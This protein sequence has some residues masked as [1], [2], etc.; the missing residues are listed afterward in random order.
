[1]I[2]CPMI[3]ISPLKLEFP[4][5]LSVPV[6]TSTPEPLLLPKLKSPFTK[7]I[8]GLAS[9]P[10]PVGGKLHGVP[11]PQVRDWAAPFAMAATRA[12]SDE[13]VDHAPV[14]WGLLPVGPELTIAGGGMGV[15]LLLGPPV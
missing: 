8:S 5:I 10:K 14:N 11:M 3:K 1:M 7:V 13:G 2:P 15:L 12:F 6:T 9:V 4:E